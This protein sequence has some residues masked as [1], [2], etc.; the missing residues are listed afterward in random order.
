MSEIKHKHRVGIKIT[1]N[2]RENGYIDNISCQNFVG[3]AEQAENPQYLPTYLITLKGT[4]S[5]VTSELLVDRR[6]I[7]M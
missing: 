5:A 7:D 1:Q 4:Y 2:A 6:F 3:N